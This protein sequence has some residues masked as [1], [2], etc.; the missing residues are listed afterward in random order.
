[1]QRARDLNVKKG[2]PVSH[3]D[4]GLDVATAVASVWRNRP[5]WRGRPAVAREGAEAPLATWRA[6]PGRDDLSAV[7]MANARR[8]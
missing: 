7:L 2:N 3:R 5:E 1:V 8:H 6:A 4:V